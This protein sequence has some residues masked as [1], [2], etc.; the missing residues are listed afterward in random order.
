MDMALVLLQSICPAIR[1]DLF[2]N[3]YLDISVTV[4]EQDGSILSAAIIG[5]SIALVLAGV[6]MLDSVAACSA[7]LAPE[8]SIFLVDPSKQ[9]ERVSATRFTLA[10]MPNR[11]QLT[12][13]H[14][15]GSTSSALLSEALSFGNDAVR[16]IYDSVMKPIL[17]EYAS[18]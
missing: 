7:V 6:E 2:P 8:Q 18:I 13:L 9:E 17:E 15:A 16:A 12:Q 4:L 3:A 10:L 1:R 14:L 11:S 5:T